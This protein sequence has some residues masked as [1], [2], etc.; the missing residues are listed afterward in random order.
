MREVKTVVAAVDLEPDTDAVLARPIQVATV[1]AARLVV[2]H[3]IEAGPLPQAAAQMDVS[4]D[5][6]QERLK[7]QALAAI[8][9]LIDASG[10][11]RR[12]DIQ[13]EIGSPHAVVTRVATERYAD[14][15]VIGPGKARTFREKTLGSTA[16]RIVRASPA[17]VLIV[18]KRSSE[19]YR[20]VAVAVDFSLQCETALKDVLRLAPDAA[21]ELVHA[22]DIP[23]GFAQALLR[24]R[25]SE[26][27]TER[28]RA[29]RADKARGELA[30]L[31][32]LA[33]A[34][35]ATTRVLDGEP[36]RA[37]VVHVSKS[38]RMDLL[39]M[40]SHGRGVAL[41]ALLGSVAQRVLREAGCDVLVAKGP[42]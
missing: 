7:R 11:T 19:P 5:E 4:E 34:H 29:T 18:R 42:D 33:G 12:T 32:R 21:L 24:A 16:D 3:V 10:R 2:L 27:T 31:A 28:Y 6:L 38:R 13:V 8:E 1:H 22:V 17:P 25:T 40:G 26:P 36:G 14:V 9:A 41:R 30:E 15:V 39:A 23:R 20:R 37:L 35:K